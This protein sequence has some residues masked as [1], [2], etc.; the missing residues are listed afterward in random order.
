MNTVPFY[1]C[2]LWREEAIGY[3]QAAIPRIMGKHPS[4]SAFG[5]N[6]PGYASATFEKERSKM[7]TDDFVKQ[8]A[9]ALFFIGTKYLEN[10]NSYQLKHWAER[11]GAEKGLAPYVSNGAFIVAALMFDYEPKREKDG[12]NCTFRRRGMSDWRADNTPY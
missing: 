5:W 10:H 1:D 11:W 2:P 3:A 4:L 8:V 6:Y 12:P 9:T 7:Q